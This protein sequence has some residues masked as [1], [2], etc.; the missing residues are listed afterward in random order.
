MGN[1][2]ITYNA[3]ED[4]LRISATEGPLPCPT[5]SANLTMSISLLEIPTLG[6]ILNPINKLNLNTGYEYEWISTLTWYTI[7]NSMSIAFTANDEQG[8]RGD[9]GC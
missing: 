6:P 3:N 7:L 9:L 4:S 2:L 1:A 5:S 8:Y